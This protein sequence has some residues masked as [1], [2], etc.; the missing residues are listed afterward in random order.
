MAVKK[1]SSPLAWVGSI[2][3]LFSLTAGIYGGWGFLSR[4]LEK[5]HAVDTLLA[6]EAVQLRASDYRSAWKTLTRADTLDPNSARIRHAQQDAAMQWLD[7][8]HA[9]DQTF[10][11]ITELLDPVLTRGAASAP[12]PQRQ[13]DLLA[14]LG[15][16]Y[17]L[18][19]R[20]VP[21]GPDPEAAYRETLEKDP[22]NPY[23][24]AMWGHWILWNHQSPAGSSQHFAAALASPRPGLR[25]YIRSMQLTALNNFHTPETS[26]ELIRVVNEI[27]KE[28]ADLDA[29]WPPK[30]LGLYW[31]YMAP[32][33]QDTA[34]FLRAVSPAEHLTAF[35]WLMQRSS[36][37]DRSSF[38]LSWIRAALLENAGLGPEALVSY[39]TL[40]SRFGNDASYTLDTATRKAVARL[41]ARR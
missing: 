33:S 26:A 2:T 32:S 3:A 30:I 21:I 14:H 17:F 20:E 34:A 4:Q 10:T 18:R 35:D 6:A 5:R 24:H 41:S 37:D 38:T 8:I 12:T 11:S 28:N 39:R 9:G 40:Q 31:E 22:G 1:P 27:R 23:A 13:A 25:P 7:N 36:P 19:R 29:L 15:W 16:S